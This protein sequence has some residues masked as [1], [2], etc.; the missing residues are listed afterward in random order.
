M[1]RNSIYSPRLFGGRVTL[2]GVPASIPGLGTLQKI[3]R[4]PCWKLRC[5]VHS[6]LRPQTCS[7]RSSP[8]PS[9]LGCY[10]HLSGLGC[11]AVT[12]H[13]AK[14]PVCTGTLRQNTKVPCCTITV[15]QAMLVE[16]CGR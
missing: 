4:P 9:G 15:I 10:P 11:P 5:G 7:A 16:K 14:V 3:C 6:S 2:P 8:G 12:R 13:C 1:R